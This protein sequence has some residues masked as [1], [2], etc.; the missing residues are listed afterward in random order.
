MDKG[1]VTIQGTP[2]EV[3]SRVDELKQLRLDVPQVTLL[4]HELRKEGFP[5]PEG[6]LTKEEFRDAILKCK[7]LI[8]NR[9]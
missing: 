5:I 2:K 4:A 6:I 9:V 3:F 7:E 1:S 8:L